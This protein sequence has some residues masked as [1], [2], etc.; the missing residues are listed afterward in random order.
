LTFS[1]GV[2][3]GGSLNLNA[4]LPNDAGL[5][6]QCFNLQAIL[7]DGTQAFGAAFSNGLELSLCDN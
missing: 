6:G 1:I 7:A 3:P 4:P 2:G 5:L